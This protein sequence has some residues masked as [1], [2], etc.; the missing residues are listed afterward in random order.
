MTD[1]ER[2]P[3]RL[4]V[5]RIVAPG[6]IILLLLTACGGAGVA[7]SPLPP[8]ADPDRP[9]LTVTHWQRLFDADAA[10]N[11]PAEL[12]LSLSPDSWDFYTLSYS[13]DELAGMFEATGDPKYADRALG[14]VE[15]MMSTAR[16]SSS[17]P[18]GAFRDQ[19]LGWVSDNDGPPQEISLYESYCW[20][21]VTRLLRTV[22]D[23]PLA[24]DPAYRARYDRILSFAETNIFEK[25][26][27]RGANDT[28]Y[29][30]RT[31]M[32]AHWAY[33]ALDLATITEDP[34][35]SDRYREV[36][37]NIDNDLPNYPSSLRGQ[38]R[39]NDADPDAYWWSDVWGAPGP[40]QDVSHGNA[41]V[42]YVVEARDL[43]SEWSDA[44]VARFSRTLT[45][46]VIGRPGA[47]PEFVDGTGRGNGWL[48]DGFVKLGRYSPAVQGALETYDV[49]NSQYYAAMAVNA[50]RLGAVERP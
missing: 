45:S 43:G 2:T 13:I 49:Q 22:R 14:F 20:R 8:P 3:A 16:A 40:P 31:H 23:S 5:G 36:V 17:L 6:V 10:V 41:V 15:N 12:R 19:Y 29:R 27:V 24:D 26:Y 35:R 37:R 9:L 33:I 25:W 34:A 50:K 42:A 11:E 48:A 47:H 30:S 1:R 32:A 46:F 44:D 28:I 21:Y 38:L 39:A 4:R 18:G 7:S